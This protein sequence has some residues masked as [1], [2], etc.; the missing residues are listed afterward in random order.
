[1]KKILV[2]LGLG[3]RHPRRHSTPPVVIC[4]PGNCALLAS[5]LLRPGCEEL[6]V[7]NS[8]SKNLL[9]PSSLLTNRLNETIN[10]SSSHARL[11]VVF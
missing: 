4:R 6:L 2:T 7:V 8:C 1:L 3:L 10:E 9:M 5:P 11:H